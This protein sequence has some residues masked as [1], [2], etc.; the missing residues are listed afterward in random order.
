MMKSA[1]KDKETQDQE[2]ERWHKANSAGWNWAMRDDVALRKLWNLQGGG[3]YLFQTNRR[4]AT[5]FVGLVDPECFLYNLA[6]TQEQTL[7]FW[8]DALGV[9]QLPSRDEVITFYFSAMEAAEER[10]AAFE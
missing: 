8:K 4:K 9:D 2:R 1:I 5:V 10:L 7:A 3:A 6:P